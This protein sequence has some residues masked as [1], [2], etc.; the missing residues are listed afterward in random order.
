MEN[1]NPHQIAQM[2][3]DCAT[4]KLDIDPWTRGFLK[5]PDRCVTVSF[6]V[7][8]AAI[9]NVI[10]EDSASRIKA[11]II[12]ELVNAPTTPEEDKILHNS[13]RFIIPASQRTRE[14]LRFPTFSGSRG[15]WT[16]LSSGLA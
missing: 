3:F 15:L 5:T 11:D 6:P 13:N 7:I 10:T 4:D 14:G 16:R 2:Q 9:G 1:L 8:P 12:L